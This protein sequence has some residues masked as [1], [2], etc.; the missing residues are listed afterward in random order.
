MRFTNGR[1]IA[2]AFCEK[3]GNQ[4]TA[5]TAFCPKCGARA[6]SPAPANPIPPSAAVV[7]ATV[8]TPAPPVATADSAGCGKALLIIGVI[9][10]LCVGL[11]IAGVVYV[12]YRAKKKVDEI[13]QEIN[14]EDHKTAGNRSGQD[15]NPA[16]QPATPDG[17]SEK[18][19]ADEKDSKGS[20]LL[21]HVFGESQPLPMYVDDVPESFMVG[22]S[23]A[24][25]CP[26]Y[27]GAVPSQGPPDKVDPAKIPLKPGMRIVNA[28]RRF[29]GDV[30][31]IG[32]VSSVEKNKF[33]FDYS[34]TG[35]ETNKSVEGT[36]LNTSRTVC[37][38]DLDAARIFMTEHEADFPNIFPGTTA[39]T[40]PLQL[41][42]Q[43]KSTGKIHWEY[44]EYYRMG[45]PGR[46]V[47][48]PFQGD[49]ARV[50]PQD[51]PFPLILNDEPVQVPTIHL[52]GVV[53]FSGAPKIK[54]LMPVSE[55]ENQEAELYVTDNPE[56]P[57]CLLYKEGSVFQVK[58]VKITVPIQKPVPQL[59]EQLAKQ[60]KAVVYGIYFD[61]DKDTI[62]PESEPVLKEIVKAMTDN[63]D[64]KLRVDGHTD[65]IG[66]DAHNL[67]LSKRRAASVKK[68][69]VE[70]YNISADRL[71]TNGFGASS[72]IDRND[73]LEG[74]ARNRRVELSR[75]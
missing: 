17:R 54:K 75:E 11:G 5:G 12:G 36:K 63:P 61:F 13:K 74:R 24:T 16:P 20:G 44:R 72:P 53:N 67:D 49:L 31:G 8:P 34:S 71:T 73:T 51:V 35:F 1:R 47:P 4:L 33:A 59:E 25:S 21:D 37:R 48:F 14:G 38:N 32:T 62:K 40:M 18:E 10:L 64:W 7:P 70:R 50:E 3:C 66:G 55:S 23:P 57:I 27:S 28:W 29:N 41:F 69:L 30:E 9:V 45:S 39:I 56:N 65:N 58:I 60:K 22:N 26:E 68:A 6:G 46:F 15:A 42:Q 52:K 43:A 19:T 2:V